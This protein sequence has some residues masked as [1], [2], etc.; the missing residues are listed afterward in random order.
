[1]EVK[2]SS[3]RLTHDFSMSQTNNNNG[4]GSHPTDSAFYFNPHQNDDITPTFTSNALLGNT[5]ISKADTTMGL[6]T[7]PST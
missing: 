2:S 4:Y 3:P 5:E 1:M 6:P 7:S